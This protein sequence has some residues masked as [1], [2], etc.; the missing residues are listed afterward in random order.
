[1]SSEYCTDSIARSAADK[2]RLQPGIHCEI[3]PPGTCRWQRC[4]WWV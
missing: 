2:Q 3:R 1:M 4:G